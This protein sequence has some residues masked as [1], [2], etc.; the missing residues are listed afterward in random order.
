MIKKTINQNV[1]FFKFRKIQSNNKLVKVMFIG[2]NW[3]NN[4]EACL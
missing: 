1:H 4:L 2:W 3:K